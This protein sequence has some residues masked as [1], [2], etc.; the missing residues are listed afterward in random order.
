MWSN[1]QS[2]VQAVS[3]PWLYYEGVEAMS[4]Y[5]DPAFTTKVGFTDTDQNIQLW[6]ARYSMEGTFL[7]WKKATLHKDC[8][9]CSIVSQ[10]STQACLRVHLHASVQDIS[11]KCLHRC[12]D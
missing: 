3:Q 10:R 1:S 9:G 11:V 6:V 5:K 8:A 7:G 12:A 4:V 2:Q